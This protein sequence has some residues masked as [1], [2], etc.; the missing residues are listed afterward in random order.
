MWI[1]DKSEKKIMLS[2]S[3]NLSKLTMKKLKSCR[4]P[5]SR[6]NK[7]SRLWVHFPV[8]AFSAGWLVGRFGFNGPLRQY[9]SLYRAASQRGR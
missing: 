4:I 2:L 1:F 5:F 3:R 9:S 6:Q 8:F 7:F